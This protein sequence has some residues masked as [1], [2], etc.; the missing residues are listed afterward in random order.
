MENSTPVLNYGAKI[1]LEEFNSRARKIELEFEMPTSAQELD[2]RRQ[3]L[4]AML[5]YKLGQDFPEDRRIRLWEAQKSFHKK[6]M[7]HT[8]KALIVRPWDPLGSM[9]K[10]LMKRF[11]KELN[12]EELKQYFDLSDTDLNRFL[13]KKILNKEKKESSV[14]QLKRALE[15]KFG[16]QDCFVNFENGRMTVDLKGSLKTEK[17]RKAFNEQVKAAAM[18]PEAPP[19]PQDPPSKRFKR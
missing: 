16:P 2:I 15:E 10:D 6:M 7:L 18:V 19:T 5:D 12:A 13:G 8:V 3:T 17:G 4:N 1:S 9:G 11:A 14:E